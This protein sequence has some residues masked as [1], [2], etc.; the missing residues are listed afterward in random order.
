MPD[1]LLIP[2]ESECGHESPCYD[3]WEDLDGIWCIHSFISGDSPE[4][5]AALCF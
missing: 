4:V 5:F 1:F 2:H 3:L